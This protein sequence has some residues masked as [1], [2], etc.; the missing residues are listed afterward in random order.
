[1]ATF[2]KLTSSKLRY[3]I[4]QLDRTFVRLAPGRA[5][6]RLVGYSLFEGR[7]VTTTG[8]W[9]NPVVFSNL[10]LAAGREGQRVDRPAFIVGMG[11]S[12]T[13]L[14]GR[15]LAAHP[16][17]G[18]LNE[19]KAMWH[20]IRGDE[21]IVG[22]YAPPGTA[23]LYLRSEDA[24]AK[25]IQRGHALFAWYLR[26][27]HSKRVVDK[28]P[29]LIFRHAFVRTIFPD[30]RFLIA[31][32]SPWSTLTSVARWSENHAT[33]SA[34]WWGVRDQKW[35]I[36]WQQGVVQRASNSDLVTL[37]LANETD[38]QVRAAIEWIVAMREAMSLAAA[39]PLAQVIHYDELVQRPRK[40]ICKTLQFCELPASSRTEAYAEEIVSAQQTTSH[41]DASSSR[42]PHALTSAVDETWSRLAST[43]QA[44][45]VTAS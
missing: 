21:D 20:V 39:D 15:I 26:A 17:V 36:L 35:V 40:V 29:E 16:S 22:S 34:D 44:P 23:R 12:G 31:V 11:R 2:S 14:L 13:T 7:P 28:Y 27:S 37:D 4:A 30:A 33:D 25:V 3:M 19:P 42:L 32:R 1:M 24:D 5:A 8:R 45:D 10:R 9:W 6:S 18:F 38:H 41:G 43:M